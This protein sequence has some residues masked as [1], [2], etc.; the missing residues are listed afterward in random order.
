M[1]E[2]RE[3]ANQMDRS[4]NIKF[5]TDRPHSIDFQ[6]MANL[7]LTKDKTPLKNTSTEMSV[8]IMKEQK[9]QVSVAS[10]EVDQSDKNLSCHI[11]SDQP[12]CINVQTETADLEAYLTPR[13]GKDLM[14]PEI[15]FN[16]TSSRKADQKY[17]SIFS[18]EKAELT[19]VNEHIEE[20]DKSDKSIQIEAPSPPSKV[21]VKGLHDYSEEM[22]AALKHRAHQEKN[23]L[24]TL[25]K[26]RRISDRS[27]KRKKQI[28]E[29][30]V[31]SE[32]LQIQ[33]TQRL[34][35]QGWM[36]AN[37]IIAHLEKDKSKVNRVIEDRRSKM[38]PTSQNTS[39]F[40]AISFCRSENSVAGVSNS[41]FSNMSNLNHT[42]DYEV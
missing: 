2:P 41:S 29:K 4:L 7:S 38:S 39:N 27:Y 20:I 30:W 13:N 35:L 8:V 25:L 28:V 1:E 21:V 34:L 5:D 24:K 15:D 19:S 31:E 26:N 23:K 17:K 40:S 42:T 10:S 22:D 32:A 16:L 33:K 36:K 18:A 11:P 3:R 6:Q 14:S 9:N 37:E 12:N